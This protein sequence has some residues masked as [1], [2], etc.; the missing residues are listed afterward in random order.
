MTKKTVLSAETKG[1]HKATAEHY[2]DGNRDFVKV[3]QLRVL[4]TQ[5]G[6]WWFA[7]GLDIDYSAQGS[8][9]EQV[10]EKFC[11]GLVATAHLYIEKFGT[12][13]KLLKPAPPEALQEFAWEASRG[14]MVVVSTESEHFLDE[15]N[16]VDCTP[17]EGVLRQLPFAG[18]SYFQ[19]KVESAA[20]A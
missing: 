4:V 5:D 20:L 11:H 12:I 15:P 2:K 18:I 8:S 14:L 13:Q 3:G 1:D 10:Q 6:S 9:L 19:R 17:R 16:T 7:Q